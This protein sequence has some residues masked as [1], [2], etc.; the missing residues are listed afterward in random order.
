MLPNGLYKLKSYPPVRG[1]NCHIVFLSL[2][3]LVE[4][5]IWVLLY[6]VLG[7]YNRILPKHSGYENKMS[8]HAEHTAQVLETLH[9]E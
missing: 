5:W 6:F 4:Q 3:I 9:T 8:K 1:W 7:G 2:Y